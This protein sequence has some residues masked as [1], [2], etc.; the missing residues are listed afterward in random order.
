MFSPDDTIAAIATP[1]GRGGLGI[2]RISGPGS[3][4]IARAMLDREGP[5]VPRYATLARVRGVD[6]VIATL[7]VAP[8][9]YTGQDVVEISAHGSPVVLRTIV[10]AALREGARLAQPGEFTLRAYLNARLDLVQA[11]A[12]GDLI[13]AATPLQ[14]RTAFDQLEGTLTRR[15]ADIDAALFDVVARLE[16]SLDFPDEGYHFIEPQDIEASVRGVVGQIDR[17]LAD[18]RRGRTVRE[19]AQVV[20]AGRPNVGKSSVFNYLAGHDRAIVTTVP[21][22][23][24]D[25]VSERVDIDGLAI[26]LVDTA[27]V[28]DTADLVEREGVER[29]RRA[30]TVATLIVVVLDQS[31]ALRDDDWEVLEATRSRPRVIVRNKADLSASWEESELTGAVAVSLSVGDAWSGEGSVA[32]SAATGHG[33]ERLRRAIVESLTSREELR[34]PPAISNARHIALL[35]NARTHLARAAAAAAVGVGTPEEFL[36]TDLQQARALLEEIT[37]RRTTDDLLQHIFDRFCIG[38]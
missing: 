30:A 12:V 10:D 1:P 31:E 29:A 11:E 21:G 13:D 35:E 26:T 36:L 4:S 28:R 20:I 18:S 32:V 34:D 6:E 7:F 19:G 3:Q 24:R 33:M 2:V 37:G 5:L 27:G 38:K 17:L 15:I 25:L 8:H 16:A 22:T 14:A 23:T 9:S